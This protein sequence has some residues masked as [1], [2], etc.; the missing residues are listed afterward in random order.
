MISLPQP[1]ALHV[2]QQADSDTT[3]IRLWLHGRS[4]RTQRAYAG[5]IQ[6]FLAFVQKPLLHVTLGDL[7]AFADSLLEL[8]PARPA[9]Y[10]PSRACL[11]LAIRAA[12]WC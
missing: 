10:Q 7:Q 6:R 1:A 8:A 5:D 9:S 12:T 11:P 3:L 4:P 2:P